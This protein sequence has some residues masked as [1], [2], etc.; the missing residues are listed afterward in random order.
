MG[1]FAIYFAK[2][3]IPEW[4]DYYINYIFLKNIVSNIKK[5]NSKIVD[6]QT[7]ELLVELTEEELHYLTKLRKE[8]EE[9]LIWETIHFNQF[10]K[11]V[12]NNSIKIKLFKIH[13]N[14]QVNNKKHFTYKEKQLNKKRIKEACER[15]YKELSLM[16]RYL[17]V[18]FK[19]IYKC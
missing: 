13:M 9:E 1:R 2:E 12:Y 10:F 4:W 6:P 18:N 16:K 5:F 17:E 7:Q 15:Y 14:L 19:I 8:L 11:H 3:K